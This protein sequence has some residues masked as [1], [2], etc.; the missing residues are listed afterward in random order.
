MVNHVRFAHWDA[1]TL[2]PLPQRYIRNIMD[3]ALLISIG[4]LI[5]GASSALKKSSVT[6]DINKLG[7]KLDQVL[8]KLDRQVDNSSNHLS[9]LS[10][11]WTMIYKDGNIESVYK[12]MYDLR[13]HRSFVTFNCVTPKFIKKIP[14]F[15]MAKR[16]RILAGEMI[17]KQESRGEVFDCCF[18]FTL[19][20]YDD[21]LMKGIMYE[22]DDLNSGSIFSGPYIET[23]KT[24]TEIFFERN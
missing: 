11:R 9:P 3:P 10:G 13:D 1:R 7:E 16:G 23:F 8:A 14:P 17:I 6:A 18:R 19:E 24:S 4:Q 15:Q 21:Y 2:R 22:Q 5:F 12:P 20:V